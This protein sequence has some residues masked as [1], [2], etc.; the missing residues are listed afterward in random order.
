MRKL[1]RG[2]SIM[3]F[4]PLEIDQHIRTVAGKDKDSSGII[5]TMDILHWA[6]RETWENIQRRAPHWVQQGMDH[7]SRYAA[8]TTFCRGQLTSKELS[9]KW[10]EPEA[11]TLEDLYA[12]R[13]PSHPTFLTNP[14]IRQRC[15]YLGVQSLCSVGMDEE[16]ERELDHEVRRERQVELPPWASPAEHSIHPDVVD[17]VKTGVIP[18]QT[19][20]FKTPTKTFKPVFKTLDATSAATDEAYVWSQ[21]VLATTDFEQTVEVSGKIDSYLRP[22]HWIISAKR[23]SNDVLVILSPHEVNCLLPDIR[24]SDKIYL[25]L[26]TP[27]ITRSTKPCDDLVLYSIPMVPDGWI[28][29]S[30][31]TDQLNVFAGQLY[32]K[33]YETYIRLCRFLCVYTRDLQ[34][35]REV[36][37]VEPDGFILPKNR[38]RHSRT[39][40]AHTFSSTPNTAIRVLLALRNKGIDYS[41]THMGKILHGRLLSEG[42]F[43][44]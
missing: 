7:T 26:Y 5:D 28:P 40:L 25:H 37:E 15:I 3:F 6:I 36:F 34:G 21:S 35:E 1:G 19:T 11:K 17:F 32:L 12:P 23:D 44:H 13:N 18:S 8:W 41:L 4:A 14:D 27:C 2:H 33:D 39:Q 22:V 31:L 24:L 10:L 20:A 16:Q 9:D 42:D 29:P 38:P 30:S 43:D